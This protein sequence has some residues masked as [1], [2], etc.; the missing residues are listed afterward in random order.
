MRLTRLVW[1]SVISSLLLGC[2]SQSTVVENRRLAERAPDQKQ[3]ARTRLALG[4]SYL[5]RG[6]TAQA[7]FNLEKARE[8]DD[9]LPEV[10]NALAYYYQVVGEDDQAER[11][12]RQSLAR[13]SDNPD[14]YNNFGAFLCQRGQYAQAQ[15]LLLAAVKKSGYIRVADSYEN[16]AL[17]ARS[18]QNFS[19][20]AQYLQQALRHN[21]NK[22][23]VLYGLASLSYAMG[24]LTKAAEYQQR[25]QQAGQ[26]SPQ[27]T[28]LRYLIASRRDDAADK[29]AAEQLMMSVYPSSPEA[30]FILSG[31]FSDAEPEQLRQQY[32]STLTAPAPA[33]GQQPQIKIVRRKTGLQPE[34]KAH[35]LTVDDQPSLLTPARNVAPV[36]GMLP[37]RHQVKPGETLY[38]IA[39]HYRLSVTELQQLNQLQQPTD[40]RSG[41]WLQLQVAAAIPEL[42][43][44][45]DGDTLFSIAFKFN[46]PMEQ[47]AELNKLNTK[48]E[49]KAGQQIR[50]PAAGVNK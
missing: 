14:T 38:Q 16:L 29:Q 44:V 48:T 27:V 49:L 12:Y 31:D 23:S 46:V 50:L 45:Q 22:V 36:A 24:D 8:I 11:A 21:G 15:E 34:A 40:I 4:V 47:L 10:H 6:D 13:D 19:Q 25:L 17:C 39:S 20:Y 2:V 3:M 1:L 28:L 32:K 7:R 18:Q 5:E 35:A 43:Q 41:Q 30:G 9:S 26:M 37:A 42:Y 33:E